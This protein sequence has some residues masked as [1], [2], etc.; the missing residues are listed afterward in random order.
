M[1]APKR[2]KA[3]DIKKIRADLLTKQDWVC[4]LCL[5]NLRHILPRQR[6]V[7]HD[8]SLTGPSAGAIRG[9]LCS[10]CNGNDGRIRRRVICSKGSLTEIQWLENLLNYWKKHATNQTGLIHHTW[11]TPD[12]RRLITNRKARARRRVVKG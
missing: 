10:N 11:K 1:A 2:I 6:C 9:V 3:G 8:H 5:R 4:P 7:D 12:E